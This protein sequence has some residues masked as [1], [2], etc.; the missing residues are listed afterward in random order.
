MSKKETRLEGIGPIMTEVQQ[1]IWKLL[2]KEQVNVGLLI[3][4]LAIVYLQINTP[5]IVLFIF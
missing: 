2:L 1:G 5:V 3:G 4:G